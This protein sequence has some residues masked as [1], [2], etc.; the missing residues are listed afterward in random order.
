MNPRDAGLRSR[1][2]RLSRALARS[3]VRGER[4]LRRRALA[5]PGRAGAPACGGPPRLARREPQPAAE[6]PGS[7]VRD[8][9]RVLVEVR[10]EPVRRPA[11]RPCAKPAAEVV[12]LSEPLPDGHRRGQARAAA[13]ARQIAAG[14]S[15]GDRGADA[16]VR[17]PLRRRGH[18]RGRP[19]LDAAAAREPSA[20]T[21]AAS[22]SASSPTPSTAT[23]PR[24]RQCRRQDVRSG[25]LPGPGN[26]CGTTTR[27]TCSTTSA[28]GTED[29]DE[30]RAMAQIVHDL[31]PGATIAFATA[32][33]GELHVRRKHQGAGRRR[34]RQGDRRRRRL[35][36]RAVLPGRAGRGRGRRSRLTAGASYFSAAGNDNLIDAKGRDIASWEAPEF[37]GPV[38]CPPEAA[39]A[40]ETGRHCLDFD[41]GAR[42]RHRPSGSASS[43]GRR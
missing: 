33:N 3:A 16:V 24:R 34:R 27:S 4:R 1:S 13:R 30:G 39:G 23:A 25:D 26:P 32:F 41:P 14:R 8:G 22:P 37:R 36:R 2:L 10:F 19:Q 42:H 17:A 7:L 38:S 11:S 9:N 15:R 12:H 20:S 43:K 28:L 21:A 31:A 29:T 35:L 18:L 5:A 40:A 6:G